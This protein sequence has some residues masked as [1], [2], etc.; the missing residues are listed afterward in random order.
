MGNWPCKSNLAVVRYQQR[1]SLVARNCQS[2][3]VYSEYVVAPTAIE[4]NQYRFPS[5]T[6]IVVFAGDSAS[7]V[8][9]TPQASSLVVNLLDVDSRGSASK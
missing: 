3:A 7:N 1:L 5:I 8:G 9:Y 2:T 6:A 4:F